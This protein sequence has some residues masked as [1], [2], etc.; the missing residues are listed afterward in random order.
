MSDD[1]EVG[2]AHPPRQHQFKKGQSGNPRGRPKD[3]KNLLTAIREELEGEVTITEN[4]RAKKI[5]K[6]AALL[7][8]LYARGLK[9]D[10]R[11]GLLFLNALP[12]IGEVWVQEQKDARSRAAD[13][14]VEGLRELAAV[15]HEKKPNGSKEK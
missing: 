6:A 11:A 12:A 15:I 7:K 9:G 4:G 2:Y 8:A 13:A 10:T 14:I 5:T 1:Y 3:S